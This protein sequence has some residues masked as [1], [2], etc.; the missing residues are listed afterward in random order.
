MNKHNEKTKTKQ[1]KQAKTKPKENKEAENIVKDL[2]NNLIGKIP[3]QA[4]LTK[5]REYR[6]RIEQK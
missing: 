2:L 4:E 3:I 1:N 5:M 6:K